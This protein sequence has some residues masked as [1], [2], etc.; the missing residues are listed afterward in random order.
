MLPC[1]RILCSSERSSLGAPRA[2]HP[3]RVALARSLAFL[4][5]NG[6]AL[7]QERP[8]SSLPAA[9]TAE[10]S[11]TVVGEN[12]GPNKGPFSLGESLV[13][14]QRT[15]QQLHGQFSHS[16]IEQR[17]GRIPASGSRRVSGDDRDPQAIHFDALHQVHQVA[18]GDARMGC[19]QF[20]PRAS[21][22]VGASR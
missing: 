13:Q 5:T 6:F 11:S 19:Y 4:C 1:E 7:S 15:R 3:K 20:T 2:W 18:A 8:E 9:S 21:D 22:V 17:G 12:T 14:G 10:Q 16:A